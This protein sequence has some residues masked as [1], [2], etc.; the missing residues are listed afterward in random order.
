MAIHDSTLAPFAP[1]PDDREASGGLSPRAVALARAQAE[2]SQDACR[3]ALVA[4]GL[5]GGDLAAGELSEAEARQW[6]MAGLVGRCARF[7]RL[8]REVRAVQGAPRTTVLLAGESGTGKE[9]LARA[10]HYGGRQAT[11]PFV[12]V[13]C[14][15]LGAAQA[16]L[17]LFGQ[18]KASGV[19]E[20]RGF[21]EQ[22]EGGTLFLD[23]IG[24]LPAALQGRLLR[25][26]EDGVFWPAGADQPR[27][28]NARV[29]AATH[30][31]LP[32]KVA[33][34]TFRQDLYYRLAHFPIAVPSLRERLEDVPALAAHLVEKLAAELKRPAPCLGT[35]AL[36]RLIAHAYPGNVRELRNTLERA[37][38]CAEGDELRAEHIVFA[39]QAGGATRTS[40]EAVPAAATD[41]AAPTDHQFLADLPLNLAEAERILVARAIAVAGGNLSKAARLLGINRASIYRWKEKPRPAAADKKSA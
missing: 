10:I 25:M 11:A 5:G 32:E 8:L 33:A 6:A 34:G 36:Q 16:E 19:P 40:C 12:R 1:S 26:L 29:I 18:A 23:E 27:T 24:D 37:L 22:A 30:A 13:D 41:P 9:L 4:S 3:R 15:A 14:T 28:L 2:L 20:R 39:P 35:E 21:C 38:I 31:D 7:A 17:L